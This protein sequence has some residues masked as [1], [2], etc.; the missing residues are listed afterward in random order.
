MTDELK[1]CRMRYDYIDCLRALAM[2]FVILG[3]QVRGYKV[4]FVFTSPIKIPL[5]FMI[6]GFVFNYERKQTGSFL[7][8]VFWK[9]I[10]PWLCLTVPFAFLKVPF[11]GISSLFP[12]LLEI[13]SGVTSW[14]M[15]CCIVAEIVWFFVSKWGGYWRI[16]L[17]SI[18][19]CITGIVLSSNHVLE[20]AMI[21]RALIAQYWILLGFL[22]KKNE[23]QLSELKLNHI[24]V[25]LIIYIGMGIITLK[26]WPGSCIDVHRNEYYNYPFCFLMITLG[27]V[28]IFLLAKKIEFILTKHDYSCPEIFL[29][30]GRNTLV[31][32]LLHGYNV[33]ALTYIL[34]KTHIFLSTPLLV[35]AKLVFAYLACGVETMFILRYI[36]WVLGKRNSLIS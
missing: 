10:I 24:C 25:L 35:V 6:T 12:E 31:Y 33:I 30:L 19:L 27:C 9:M 18:L 13:I 22:V 20:F 4:Y 14:Y 34:S 7:K 8:N 2:F 15:P 21:N 28:M 29:F 32:Y 16:I 23:E 26:I 11:K 3:H 5:F 17:I 1:S 36:P